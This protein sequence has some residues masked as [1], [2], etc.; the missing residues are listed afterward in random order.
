MNYGRWVLVLKRQEKFDY[1]GQAEGGRGRAG[2]PA[3]S[4]PGLSSASPS[5]TQPLLCLLPPSLYR[6]PEGKFEL[7]AADGLNEVLKNL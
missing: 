2:E 7:E 3:L 5:T 6:P 1:G 4:E